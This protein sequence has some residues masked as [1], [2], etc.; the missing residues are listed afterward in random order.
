MRYQ[1]FN[2]RSLR[3]QAAA[4][5]GGWEL[6]N[7]STDGGLPLWVV[8]HPKSA[9]LVPRV[10]WSF[11]HGNEPTGFE[12]L[13]SFI[14][15]GVPAS[16][17]TLLPMVNPTGID[18]FTRHTR[19]GIDLNRRAREAGPLESDLLKNILRSE[20]FE[21]ALNL[22]DQRSIFHPSGQSIPSSLSVLA[23]ASNVNGVFV[24][25]S[26]AK[27]WAGSISKWMSELE[28]SWGFA[29]FD[30]SYYPTAFG[31]MVQ[32]LGIPTVTVETGIAIGDYSRTRVARALFRVLERVDQTSAPNFNGKSHYESL[33]LNQS[34]GCDF[35]I[36]S[37]DDQSFWKVWERVTNGSYT[38]GIE[39]VEEEAD[40]IPY[41]T[42]SITN[43]DHGALVQRSVWTSLELYAWA[44]ASLRDL[45]EAL[46]R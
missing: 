1:N 31:E 16:N 28:P 41:Q 11:M 9:L 10:A 40:L 26:V 46:P 18:M 30:E 19:D 39:R 15:Q 35:L 23:P 38:A 13:I 7:L 29:R 37:N 4:R 21:L 2:N 12:S 34:T 25:P 42:L 6:T 27:A 22:H 14:E 43:S 8:R 32:E 3:L 17:W 44:S 5:Q 45:V 20:G 33:P 36:Q 24:Q